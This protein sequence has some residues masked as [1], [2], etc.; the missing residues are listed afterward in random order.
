[1]PIFGASLVF[2]A[3]AVGVWFVASPHDRLARGVDLGDK[4]EFARA[5]DGSKDYRVALRHLKGDGVPQD[6]KE[7]VAWLERSAQ[8]G[9][10]NA[11]YDLGI[12]LRDGVGA[13]A[14][15]QRALTW[16]RLAAEGGDPRAQ[17]EVGRMYVGGKGGAVDGVRGFA[18]LSLAA[19]QGVVGAADARDAAIASMSPDAV[20]VAKMEARRMIDSRL[21]RGIHAEY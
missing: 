18:W 16:L 12:A 17:F 6:A 14:D 2:F 21:A 9:Y 1:M 11:Q 10:A 15:D 3:A 20:S 7:G 4:L 5:S 8:Q 13:L 19:A